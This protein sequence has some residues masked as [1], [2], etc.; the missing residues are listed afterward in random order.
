MTVMPHFSELFIHVE[1]KAF[2]LLMENFS[3]NDVD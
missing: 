1:S 3:T 2:I